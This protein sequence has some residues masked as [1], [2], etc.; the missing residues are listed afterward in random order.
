MYDGLHFLPG[1]YGI[2]GLQHVDDA[3]LADVEGLSIVIYFTGN[4]PVSYAN[5][6][7]L[8]MLGIYNNPGLE[9]IPEYFEGL[10]VDG[11]P[12]WTP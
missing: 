8:R 7:N 2:F 12:D 10:A 11:Y 4:F 3:V 6:I 9:P 1:Q 5:L